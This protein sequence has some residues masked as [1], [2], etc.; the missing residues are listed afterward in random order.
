MAHLIN[1]IEELK[2]NF[3]ALDS[4][5][6]WPSIKSFVEDVETDIITETIGED[7]LLYF[8]GNLTGLTGKSLQVLQTLIRSVAYLSVLRWSQTAIFR[9]TDKALFVAKSADGVIISDKKIT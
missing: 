8:Q 7:T 2:A 1:N 9:L 3:S 4:N 5:F 6:N